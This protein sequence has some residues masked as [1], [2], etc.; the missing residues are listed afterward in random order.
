MA[1]SAEV[2]AELMRALF[3]RAESIE[4]RAAN[5]ALTWR[6]EEVPRL[7][8]RGLANKDIARELNL[9]VATVKQHVHHVLAKL[10]PSGTPRRCGGCGMS[11]GWRRPTW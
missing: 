1:C 8:G 3:Q 6:E 11:R 2:A 4:S 5:E 10:H 9:S 7:I